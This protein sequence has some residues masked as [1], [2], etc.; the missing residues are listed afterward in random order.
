M[1]FKVFIHLLLGIVL[2]FSAVS[3]GIVL[4]KGNDRSSSGKVETAETSQLS[5]Q[6]AK[7]L[8]NEA[9]EQIEAFPDPQEVPKNHK[10]IEYALFELQAAIDGNFETNNAIK[11]SEFFDHSQNSLKILE[12]HPQ[13]PSD[14]KDSV[15]DKVISANRI[16]TDK[17]LT[18]LENNTEMFDK[19]DQK[20]LEKAHKDYE[21]GVDF[22]TKN[23]REQSIHFY[24]KAWTI[25]QE[26]KEKAK[27]I[28]DSDGD[29]LLDE[30]EKKLGTNLQEKDTDHDGLLD[31]FEIL[32][33]YTSPLKK[34]T[35]NDGSPDG[36]ED[37]DQDSLN[38]LQE[39][40]AGT[41]PVL[42]DSD[43]DG[44]D[45]RFELVE[46]GTSPLLKD[47]DHDGLDDAGE[48]NAGSDPYKNDSDHDRLYDGLESFTQTFTEKESGAVLEISGIGDLSRAVKLINVSDQVIFQDVPG[49]VSEFV[50]I[51]VNQEF[52]HATVKIP[53]EKSD[54]PNGDLESVKMYIYDKEKHTFTPLKKQ[55]VDAEKGYIIGETTQFS[56]FTLIYTPQWEEAQQNETS[57]IKASAAGLSYTI[58]NDPEVDDSDGDGLTD[59]EELSYGTLVYYHDSDMD[60]LDDGNELDMGFNPF[61]ENADGDSF[62]DLEEFN[63]ETDPDI[64]DK[65]WTDY[66]QELLLGASVNEFASTL[67]DWGWMDEETYDSVAFLLGQLVAGYLAYGD[68]VEAAAEFTQADVGAGLFALF[69]F[70][71]AVGDIAKTVE[72]VVNFVKRV[73]KNIIAATYEMILKNF[74][75]Q[76]KLLSAILDAIT[77]GASKQLRDMGSSD[78]MIAQLGKN[79]N[80]LKRIAKLTRAKFGDETLDA[81]GKA[82]I[83]RKIRDHW[84]TNLTDRKRA[85]AFGTEAA[86]W[87]YELM[88]YK[89][90]YAQRDKDPRVKARTGPDIIMKTP[91]GELF[92]I[93]AKG[94]YSKNGKLNDGKKQ[95]VRLASKVSG[96]YRLY[97]S[98][99]WLTTNSERYMDKFEDAIRNKTISPEEKEAY[100]LLKDV[101]DN[102]ASY[103]S[104]VVYGGIRDA[105][106]VI[107]AG[108]EMDDY[109]ENILK[110]TESIDFI[111]IHSM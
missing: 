80:D 9:M 59:E 91:S 42:K 36:E 2:V 89:L 96:Q 29:G 99:E 48:Y 41:N 92:I 21:K 28:L 37:T 73:P 97:L 22:E 20:L 101:I 67:V 44:L 7:Q 24:K 54:I 81:A 39:Q 87:Y 82:I 1:K 70:V 61:E 40:K 71:P 103:K 108:K 34:D 74:A 57:S 31:G 25:A 106:S 3:P 93:E 76:P 33:Q 52:E 72:K 105:K 4:G 10:R 15:I 95:G 14:K 45:D 46:F 47:T 102:G 53:I 17:L 111:L 69:G 94:S 104:S 66:I 18:L 88:G 56:V 85:E 79:G 100:D 43:A 30:A 62:T 8:I 49:A 84:G 77:G 51:S 64:Y 86:I 58:T 5:D 55:K 35:N 50:D 63:N 16:V 90:L 78:K 83:N 109:L 26:L 12:N 107:E 38:N 75:D 13:T 68:I 60:G 23:N 110:D 19:K 98:R 32:Q 11:S 6:N 65:E 27:R